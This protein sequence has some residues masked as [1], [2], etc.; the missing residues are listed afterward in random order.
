MKTITFILLCLALNTAVVRAE[1]HH[2]VQ[3]QI[4]DASAPGVPVESLTVYVLVS[5]DHR[6]QVFKT[7]NST[8]MEAA[9]GNLPRGSVLHYDANAM[10][11]SPPNSQLQALIAN[12]KKRDIS[13]M[14][15]PTN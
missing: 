3:T 11:K 5:P 6:P 8:Q 1:E 12:C 2:L 9:I 4:Q 15:S 14:L 13:L 10:I 7:F